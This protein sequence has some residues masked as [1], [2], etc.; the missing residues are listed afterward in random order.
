M[1]QHDESSLG[2]VAQS[3]KGLK[4]IM[5]SHHWVMMQHPVDS[6]SIQVLNISLLKIEIEIE[7]EIQENM[8]WSKIKRPPLTGGA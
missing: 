1:M 4:S 3:H 5:M 2:G 7:I 6:T 8:N